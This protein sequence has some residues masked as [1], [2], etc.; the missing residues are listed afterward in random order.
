[1]KTHINYSS[2]YLMLYPRTLKLFFFFFNDTAT[3]EIYTLSLHD[4]LPIYR[5]LRRAGHHAE[6]HVRRGIVCPIFSV[7]LLSGLKTM[8]RVLITGGNGFIGSHLAEK[9]EAMGDSVTLFDTRFNGNAE[10]VHGPK[11]RGDVRDYPAVR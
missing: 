2:F 3:T 7:R 11:V 6:A 4:A 10:A 1:M 8:S 9:L 5:F